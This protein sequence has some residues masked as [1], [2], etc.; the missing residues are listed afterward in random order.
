MPPENLER[1]AT[2]YGPATWNVYDTLD[3]SLSPS[4]P[5]ELFEIAG[6]LL[7][8][9][10]VVLD[11]GCR[12]GAH[13]V[14]LAQRFDITGVGVEPVPLHIERA[15]AMV[16]AASLAQRI[17]IHEATI[18]SM[19]IRDNSIDLVWCRDVFE[20]VD[21]V[22]G[23]LDQLA[24]VT[25]PGAPMVLFTTVMTDAM[26]TDERLMMRH[27][28]GNIEQNLD[29]TWLEARF[30]DA[31]FDIDTVRSIGTEW[32]EHG[33][34][35]S[36]PLSKAMLRLARLRRRSDEIIAEHGLAIFQHVEANLHWELFQMLGKLEPLVYT[37][38]SP[39]PA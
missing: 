37:L 3:Q 19:P 5:D 31:G 24:R 20:Q 1:L 21:D 25:K 27:H 35:R 26:S 8:T 23:A 14:E 4:G 36:Q 15:R 11:A 16:E 17:E 10:F 12:D 18:Q 7:E 33:E 39:T 30:T 32:R 28:M 34:E 29:R 13:L 6:A 22:T 2:V 38:R 9:G